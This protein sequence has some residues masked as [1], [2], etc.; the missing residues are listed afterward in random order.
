MAEGFLRDILGYHDV[1]IEDGETL[2]RRH[3]MRFLGQVI[4]VDN[5]ALGSTDVT[6]VTT[7]EFLEN[8]RL[9]TQANVGLSGLA[10]VDSVT[11]IEDD[12]ILVKSQTDSL[13][14]GTYL[15]KPGAW[16][17]AL[18]MDNTGDVLSGVKVAVLEGSVSGGDAFQLASADPVQIN[19]SDIIWINAG[20]D[21][22]ELRGVNLDAATVGA[23]STGQGIFH[24]GVD[25]KAALLKN[26]NVDA[27]A[28]IDVNKL[29]DQAID[30]QNNHFWGTL[31]GNPAG[32]L[33]GATQ[34]A[35][36]GRQVLAALTD[37]D[38]NVGFGGSALEAVTVGLRNAA[39]GRQAG[40]GIVTGSD[41]ICMGYRARMWTGDP[42]SGMSIA[43]AFM[44]HFSDN[45]RPVFRIGG[46]PTEALA[47][48]S[49]ALQ[50]WGGLTF[51]RDAPAD[52]AI[53]FTEQSTGSAARSLSI[54][55][56]GHTGQV[57]GNL[58]L[59][60]GAGTSGGVFD[61]EK[62]DGTRQFRINDTG[63]AFFDGTP[64]GKP[65]ITGSRGG[66]AALASILT[67]LDSL[68]LIDDTTSA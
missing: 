64:T 42:S 61:L 34:N 65:T 50:L 24:D 43:N 52:V 3:F 19:V 49:E 55:A 67:Q 27:A 39:F 32:R 25:F 57:G 18:D 60:A 22:A 14:N 33:V 44:G 12:R 30:A 58:S 5:P 6:I 31:A 46:V 53:A 68:G 17:R 45:T 28:A 54:S 36:F 23:A 59:R 16:V 7:S 8:C 41:N 62:A 26:V 66:N 40:D 13:E 20:S 63:I 51:L 37:G 4:A 21:A 15:A 29:S 10:D 9:A 11:P 2:P 35:G 1:A 47:G 56:Q 38:H 48:G